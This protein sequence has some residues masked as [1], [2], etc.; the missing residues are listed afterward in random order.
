M[1]A[2]GEVPDLRYI[3]N[4]LQE[5]W[6]RMNVDTFQMTNQKGL[7]ACGDAANGPIGTVVDAIATGKRSAFAIQAFFFC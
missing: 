7:F 4:G 2:I 6:G 1:L 3:S 5:K